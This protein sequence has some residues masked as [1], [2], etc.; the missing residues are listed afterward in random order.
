MANEIRFIV[1]HCERQR[2]HMARPALRLMVSV[3]S[4]LLRGARTPTRTSRSDASAARNRRSLSP[5]SDR[6]TV[7][8]FDNGRRAGSRRASPVVRPVDPPGSPDEAVQRERAEQFLGPRLDVALEPARDRP[9]PVR[10]RQQDVLEVV[11]ETWRRGDVRLRS[12][13]VGEVEQLTPA[14]VAEGRQA[15]AAAV[16]RPRSA[17]SGHTTPGRP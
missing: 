6:A 9:R 2:S 1:S 4:H 5:S 7:S 8:C 13:R 14:F 15:P 17:A 16:R 10:V 3:R 12:R 11:Q